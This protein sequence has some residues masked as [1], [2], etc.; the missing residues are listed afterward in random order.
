MHNNDTLEHYC[1]INVPF[2]IIP[3]KKVQ[4]Y[5]LEA[6]SERNY[7]AV[8]QEHFARTLEKNELYN[9]NLFTEEWKS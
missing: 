8:E 5:L 6:G 2:K 4:A 9:I 1:A 7:E 3:Y